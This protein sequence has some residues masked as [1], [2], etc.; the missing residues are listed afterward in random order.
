MRESRYQS[1]EHFVPDAYVLPVDSIETAID[2]LGATDYGL[3]ASVWTARRETYE[4]FYRDSRVGVLNWNTS[5]VGTSSR[6]PFGGVGRSGN[7]RPAGVL[8]TRYCTYPVASL[9][10]EHPA[11]PGSFPG[12]P[13][14]P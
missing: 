4:R 14:L 9:E 8:S 2:A 13:E 5:T 7:D 12:F 11:A 1:E 10:H 3:V 6:L